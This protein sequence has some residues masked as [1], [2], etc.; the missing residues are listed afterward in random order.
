MIEAKA[1]LFSDAEPLTFTSGLKSPVY[2]DMRKNIAFLRIRT[3]LVGRERR[4]CRSAGRLVNRGFST[5]CPSV[6]AKTLRRLPG[7]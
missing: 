1:V 5:R 7:A 2:T 4:C 6:D 3:R